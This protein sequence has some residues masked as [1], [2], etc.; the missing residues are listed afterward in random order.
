[1]RTRE[2]VSVAAFGSP[3]LISV[4][5]VFF[6]TLA[7][8]TFARADEP[9]FTDDASILDRGTCQLELGKRTLRDSHQWYLLPACNLFWDV[10]IT[11][12][13]TGFSGPLGEGTLD[14]V[15]QA[16]G[17]WRTVEPNR[18]GFGWNVGTEAGRHPRGSE[19]RLHDVTGTLIASR[20]F[21]DDRLIAHAN[22]GVRWLRDEG[23]GALTS[24]VLAE[25]NVAPRLAALFETYDTSRSR[26]FYQ[27]GVRLAIVPEHVILHLAA[28]GESNFTGTRQWTIGVHFITPP[29]V[30]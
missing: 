16:K 15:I 20:S 27:A 30:R 24:G 14:T 12:G 18:F 11:L 4:A 22:A 19:R 26:R 23:R 10:E 1:M 6:C 29:F 9:Y 17:V 3:R 2:A 8:A 28:G 13:R 7:V 5:L 25:V 21:L